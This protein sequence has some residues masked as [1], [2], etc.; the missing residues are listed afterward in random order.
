MASVALDRTVTVT[1]ARHLTIVEDEIGLLREVVAEREGWFETQELRDGLVAEVIRRLVLLDFE[2]LYESTRW[3]TYLAL[4]AV[5]ASL[6]DDDIREQV[7]AALAQSEDSHTARI[8][9]AWERLADLFGFKLRENA[10]ATFE[11]LAVLLSA[12][13]RGLVIT[14]L[15]KPSIARHRASAR[16]FG[17]IE[18]AEWSLP[19]LSCAGIAASFLEPDQTIDWGDDRMTWV[20][21]AFA[22]LT[23]GDQ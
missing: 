14:A 20:R 23:F 8:A 13:M 5:F 1:P 11:N 19:A 9:A 18:E 4:N 2:I 15:S 3:R 7:R 16:P 17:A 12:T 21:T 6:A 22:S 10:G